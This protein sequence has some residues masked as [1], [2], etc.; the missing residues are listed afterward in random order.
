SA[1]IT[2][3]GFGNAKKNREVSENV[4][5]LC[6]LCVCVC[7]VSSYC[8]EF[9]L[10]TLTLACQYSTGPPTQWMQYLREGHHMTGVPATG[11]ASWL[12][13]LCRGWRRRGAG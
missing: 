9:E 1:L 2:A 6:K 5:S 11:P 10:I 8:V 3:S 12:E 7:V 13:A 4:S